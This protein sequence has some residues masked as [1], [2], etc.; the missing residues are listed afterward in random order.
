[1]ARA[2]GRAKPDIAW[3]G[4]AGKV[5]AASISAG[6]GLVSIFAFARSYGLA[7]GPQEGH[8]ALGGFSAAWVGV[9]PATDT[10]FAIGDT[11]HLVATAKDSRGSALVGAPIRWTSD[12][13]AIAAVDAAGAVVARGAGTTAIAVTVGDRVG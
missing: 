8:L 10:A 5:L 9:T 13:P 11:L 12:D 4:R 7:G 1:M 2:V 6:T 3:A